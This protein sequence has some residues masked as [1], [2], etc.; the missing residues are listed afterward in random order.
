MAKLKFKLFSETYP[1]LTLNIVKK[2]KIWIYL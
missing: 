1:F 2:W